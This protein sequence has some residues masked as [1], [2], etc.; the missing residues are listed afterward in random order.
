MKRKSRS[1]E[2]EYWQSHFSDP[3]EMDT[4]GNRKDHC[5]YLKSLF[6]LEQIKIKSLVDLGMGLG[7]FLD[8]LRKQ[9]KASYSL[10]I[11][12]SNYAF[13]Y[14]QKKS[15]R[16]SKTT[17]HKTQFLNCGIGDWC[18]N[19]EYQD[20]IFDLGICTSVFQYLSEK[21][22][23]QIIPVMAQRIKYLYLTVP[24]KEE[25]IRLKKETQFVDTYAYSRSWE[26]YY[27]LISPYFTF[28]SNRLLESRVYFNQT[29]T[30]F[31][32]LLYRF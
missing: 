10:G 26:F 7:F 27:L 24:T 9:F 25:Y 29:N 8:A 22:L 32:E 16:N 17:L 11:E 18:Q 20:H 3:Q 12:P 28:I 31:G 6:D 19:H 5:L 14:A 21:E 4:I 23:Q 13:L 2:S 15:N 1:F 30:E